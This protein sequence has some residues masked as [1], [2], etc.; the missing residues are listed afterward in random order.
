MGLAGSVALQNRA[1]SGVPVFVLPSIGYM[2]AVFGV[3]IAGGRWG[4]AESAYWTTVSLLNA[5]GVASCVIALWGVSRATEVS[6]ISAHTVRKVPWM[7]P[8]LA[9]FLAAAVLGALA[10]YLRRN[11]SGD[12]I[13][14]AER[15]MILVVAVPAAFFVLHAHLPGDLGLYSS[16]EEGQLLVGSHQVLHG[17]FPWR[18]ILLP[19]RPFADPL[20]CIPGFVFFIVS[21]SGA[22]PG[23]F[24]LFVPL[25]WLFSCGS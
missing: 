16:F 22:W 8:G 14:K 23:F 20:L 21:R 18:D 15:W 3:A 11:P 25:F 4:P 5:A 9:L 6:I 24:L 10:F 1:S 13:W 12:R 17:A 7:P 19:P 2:A